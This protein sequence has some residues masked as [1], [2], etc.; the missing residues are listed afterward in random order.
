MSF[1][2]VLIIGQPFNNFSGGG[3]TLTNLFKGWPGDK[4]AVAYTGHGLYNITTDICKICYQ[5]GEEEHK[6]ITPFNLIQKKFPSGIKN[7]DIKSNFEA[8]HNQIGLRYVLVTRFFYPLLSWLGLSY[9]ISKISVSL[10]FKDWLSE[11]NPD[12][13]YIQAP[14]RESVLFADE[15]CDYLKIPSIIH[16][17]DDWFSTIRNKGL[18]KNYWYKK[19]NIEFKQLLNK[20]DL[21]L[22]ISDAM[23]EEYLK[24]YNTKFIAFH[25]PIEID[26]WTP[27]IKTNFNID[28][29]HVAILYSGRLGGLGIENSLREVASAVDLMDNKEIN[30]K[31][32]IQTPVKKQSI[33]DQLQKFKCVIFNPFVDYKQL[34]KTFSDADILLLANDF[35]ARGLNYLKFSMPTKASEYMISGTPVLVYASAETAVCRF[36]KDNE[37]GFCLTTQNT[38]EIVKSIRFMID[39]EDYRK[40]ISQNAIKIAKENFS[41]EIVRNKF[42][43]LL[44]SL[45]KE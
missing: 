10:K 27:Y 36:F 38:E 2:K 35:N 9:S 24:R 11:F 16:V 30:I 14:S 25:N 13:L 28:K 6:W 23:S 32:H 3:I 19:I 33:L 43:G 15:L 18:F 17:M 8:N 22:S 42:Q 40:K 26:A 1:P 44:K 29:K 5:L 39:N 7:T 41:S 21:H 20:A 31:L 34:P 37:C 45:Y 12:I 4:I